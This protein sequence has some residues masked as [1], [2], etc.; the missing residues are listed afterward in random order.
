MNLNT[1]EVFRE[2]VPSTENFAREVYRIFE[3]FGGAKLERVR[4]EETGN[5]SFEY[6]G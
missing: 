3:G 6:A 2:Q 4:I 5:N 1:L